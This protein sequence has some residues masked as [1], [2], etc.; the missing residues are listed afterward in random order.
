MVAITGSAPL[1]EAHIGAEIS[2]WARVAA[3]VIVAAV[4]TYA[5][6]CLPAAAQ[7]GRGGN[8]VT[9]GNW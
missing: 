3:G 7:M 1:G 5:D 8:A 4:P 2:C 6:S 9:V